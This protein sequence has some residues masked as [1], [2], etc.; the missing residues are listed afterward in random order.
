MT[1]EQ[2][3]KEVANLRLRVSQLEMSETEHNKTE[4]ALQQSLEQYRLLTD[5]ARVR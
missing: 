4:E 2:L 5:N 3:V 1:K